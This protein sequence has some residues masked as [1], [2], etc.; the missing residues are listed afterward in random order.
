[1][2][3]I[4]GYYDEIVLD[5]ENKNEIP[6]MEHDLKMEIKTEIEEIDSIDPSTLNY[7]MDQEKLFDALQSFEST[8]GTKM[9]NERNDSDQVN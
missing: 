4:E 6:K 8:Q 9:N 2:C 7:A 5:F 3:A 1:M